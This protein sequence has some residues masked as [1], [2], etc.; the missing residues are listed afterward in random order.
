MRNVGVCGV[1]WLYTE[2]QDNAV[3]KKKAKKIK[4]QSKELEEQLS[5]IYW[6]VLT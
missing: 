6:V 4:E 5:L 1:S 3:R 2:V